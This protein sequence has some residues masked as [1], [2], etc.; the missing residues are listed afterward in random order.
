M[1]FSFVAILAILAVGTA[2]G[3]VPLLLHNETCNMDTCVLDLVGTVTACGPAIAEKGANIFADIS[4]LVSAI[5]ELDNIP[6]SCISCVAQFIPDGNVNL[7]A[8][9][10]D[11]GTFGPSFYIILVLNLLILW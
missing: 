6:D 11:I 8:A 9:V 7:N 1:Q 10:M 4:C 2:A 3:P 5:K